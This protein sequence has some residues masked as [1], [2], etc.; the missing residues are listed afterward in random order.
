MRAWLV[1]AVTMFAQAA[2]A[3]PFAT[4]VVR[5]E[6]DA[7]L[8]VTVMRYSDIAKMDTPVPPRQVVSFFNVLRQGIDTYVEAEPACARGVGGVAKPL[9]VTG[10]GRYELTFTSRDFGRQTIL[11]GPNCALPPPASGECYADNRDIDPVGTRG[12]V[13][14]KD[15]LGDDPGMSVE[16]CVYYCQEKNFPYAGLQYGRWCFCGNTPGQR[17]DASACSMPCA[18]NSGQACGG[19]WANNVY[20]VRLFRGVTTAPPNTTNTV[21]PA[22]PRTCPTTGYNPYG[23]N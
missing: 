16:K 13:L 8:V 4:L 18:G 12:R 22:P 17:I 20:S 1:F 3:S 2:W 21:P 10:T 15:M 19:P 23:C 7:T 6:T 11:D 14:D 9:V 5:N